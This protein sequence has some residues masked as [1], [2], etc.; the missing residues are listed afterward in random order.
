MSSPESPVHPGGTG[1]QDRCRQRALCVRAPDAICFAPFGVDDQGNTPLDLVGITRPGERPDDDAIR[2]AYRMLTKFAPMILEKQQTGQIT[3][4]LIE[5]DAPRSARQE[6]GDYT[7]PVTRSGL[8]AGQGVRIGVLFL[9]TGPDQFLITGAGD[10]QITLSTD[11]PSPSIVGVLSIE[12]E[13]DY[14]LDARL[15]FRYSLVYFRY[16]LVVDGFCFGST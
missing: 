3:A 10:A 7:A 15:Y 6:V 8:G 4:A 14:I 11:K 9:Q 2:D 1:R 5:S 12:E 16:S 13:V